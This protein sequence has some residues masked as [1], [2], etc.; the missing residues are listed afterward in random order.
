MWICCRLRCAVVS[1]YNAL[2]N[3][4]C[5]T[6]RSMWNLGLQTFRALGSRQNQ[7][8]RSNMAS[9]ANAE[10][11]LNHWLK[12]DNW[13]LNELIHFGRWFSRHSFHGRQPTLW[14]VWAS[15]HAPVE[16][17]TR[18][19]TTDTVLDNRA[20]RQEVEKAPQRLAA[21]RSGAWLYRT[22]QAAYNFLRISDELD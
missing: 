16:L 9:S 13:V 3:N 14:L 4:T 6:N 11:M 17:S 19:T 18:C 12:W 5:T 2:Y 7:T 21:M 22:T 1:S 15:V 8:V 10:L 20:V